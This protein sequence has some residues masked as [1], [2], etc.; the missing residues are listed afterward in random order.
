MH[1]MADQA[2][3]YMGYSDFIWTCVLFC[4]LPLLYAHAHMFGLAR[5]LRMLFI[6]IF[7]CS[8]WS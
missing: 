7:A 4:F 1:S 6:V 8:G 3:P 2:C 5:P